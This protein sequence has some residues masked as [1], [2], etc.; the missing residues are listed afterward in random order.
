MQ[1]PFPSPVSFYKLMFWLTLMEDVL[2][3]GSSIPFAMPGFELLSRD[4]GGLSET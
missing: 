1:H 2:G 4:F 3:L